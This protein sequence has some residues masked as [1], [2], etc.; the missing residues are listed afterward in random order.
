MKNR[1]PLN[2][3]DQQVKDRTPLLLAKI[4]LQDITEPA[5][6]KI[7]LLIV[8]GGGVGTMAA[9]ALESAGQA[10]ITMVL[11]SN[12]NAVKQNGF[13]IDSIQHGHDITGWRPSHLIEKVPSAQDTSSAPFDYIIVAT[14][15]IPDVKPTVIDII[16][17]AVTPGKTS[18]L[19]LQNGLNIEKPIIARFPDNVI[20]SGVS[21]IGA[22]ETQHGVI[23]HDDTDDCRV[24]P[25]LGSGSRVQP[26]VAEASTRRLVDAY[27]A[28][29]K[30]NWEYDDDVPFTRWRKLLYNSSFNSVAAVIGMDTARMRMSEFVIDDLILPIM[31]EIKATAKAVGIDLPD[32]IE[33]KLIRVDPT[34]TA[35]VPSM[36]QDAVKVMSIDTTATCDLPLINLHREISWRSKPSLASRSGKVDA[37]EFLCR[38]WRRYMVCS[39]QSNYRSKSE[40]AYGKQNLCM[41]R[42]IR[43][44]RN[45][46]HFS[47]AYVCVV[48]NKSNVFANDDTVSAFLATHSAWRYC[49]RVQTTVQR[50]SK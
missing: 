15:N 33:Q 25:F 29:G 14:K 9:Y 37:W 35:F 7:R 20:L 12:F 3:S 48:G 5:M 32:G 34:D 4:P 2:Q 19:L 42:S 8:G 22:T 1:S 13:T 49:F 45:R 28:C 43:E 6:S 21:L 44:I 10:E 38:F 11:R 24:G 16:E 39:R 50:F 47:P 23:R 30:V 26:Q 17:E 40:K 41:M 46:S 18:I 36:G 31:L 27:N